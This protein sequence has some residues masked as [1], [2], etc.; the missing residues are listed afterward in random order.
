MKRGGMNLQ[1]M[2]LVFVFCMLIMYLGI[3]LAVFITGGC[4]EVVNQ[5]VIALTKFIILIILFMLVVFGS[6]TV[7]LFKGSIGKVV[8]FVKGLFKG[9]NNNSK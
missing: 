5:L 7:R 4:S 9:N 3:G 6:T 8:N 2:Y 1:K